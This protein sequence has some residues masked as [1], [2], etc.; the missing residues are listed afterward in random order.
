MNA[1]V[2]GV[3]GR[4]K[5][6]ISAVCRQAASIADLAQ[7]FLIYST[8]LQMYGSYGAILALQIRRRLRRSAPHRSF[9]VTACLVGAGG[10]SGTC[11]C[12]SFCS[13]VLWL[14]WC[15]GGVGGQGSS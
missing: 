6:R 2:W 5:C 4:R 7:S 14:G 1:T 15:G 12:K 8:A 9:G 10:G 11:S 13:V 3:Y